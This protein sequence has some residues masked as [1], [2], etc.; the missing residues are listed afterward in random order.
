[1]ETASVP[2]SVIPAQA[3][4]QVLSLV[5]R[6]CLG[7]DT[8]VE[9]HRHCHPRLCPGWTDFV[10]EQRSRA[11]GEV[12]ERAASGLSGLRLRCA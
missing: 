12:E 3:G 5:P 11:S 10:S 9:P 2:R 1:M 4:I 7:T 8:A 6:L